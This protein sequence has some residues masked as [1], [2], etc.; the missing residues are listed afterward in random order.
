MTGPIQDQRE[1]SPSPTE[2]R[3]QTTV[4]GSSVVVWGFGGGW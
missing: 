3:G 2:V 4:V 1:K